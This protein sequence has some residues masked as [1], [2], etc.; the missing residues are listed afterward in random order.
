[1]L[2]RLL[3][4]FALVTAPAVP[5]LAAPVP[6]T[7]TLPSKYADAAQTPI[8][9]NKVITIKF[10]RGTSAA[11][12][13][14]STT[15]VQTATTCAATDEAPPGQHYYVATATVDS[16]E[17]TRTSAVTVVVPNLTPQ[18]PSNLQATVQV[19]NTNAYKQRLAIDGF[20]LVAVGKFPA[21]T[22][23]DASN[24]IKKD[25][26][27]YMLVPRSNVTLNNRFDTLPTALYAQCG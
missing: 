19:A 1:M 20:S 27:E 26:V 15:P 3:I 5:A 25:G 11:A 4:G 6:L 13:A 12:A 7:C 21:G 10:Y 23:C 14:A 16:V 8:P 17:S 9:A 2:K 18:P 22:S 24:I